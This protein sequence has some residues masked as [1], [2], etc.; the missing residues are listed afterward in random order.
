MATARDGPN[1]AP[2]PAIGVD[3]HPILKLQS[4][5]GNRRGAQLI[6]AKRLAAAGNIVG[7]QCKLTVG[8]DDDQYEREADRVAKP[9]Y[10]AI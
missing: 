4:V 6:Q 7:I 8:V 2:V 3:I 1:P 5:L 10:P 9:S